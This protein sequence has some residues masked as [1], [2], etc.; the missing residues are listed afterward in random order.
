MKYVGNDVLAIY[1]LFKLQSAYEV[2]K[3]TEE[4]SELKGGDRWKFLFVFNL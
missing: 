2:K 3:E 4:V 1:G